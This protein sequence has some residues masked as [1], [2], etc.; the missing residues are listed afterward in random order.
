MHNNIHLEIFID[1]NCQNCETSV[2]LASWVR[3]NFP[4]LSIKVIDIA[5][6]TGKIP[7]TVYAVPTYLLDGEI[8][9]LGNPARHDLRLRIEERLDSADR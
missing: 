7:E 5:H 6:P 2:D 8:I 4:G 1:R 3:K 9:S